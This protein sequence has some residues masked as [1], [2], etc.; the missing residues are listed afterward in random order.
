MEH[1]SSCPRPSDR[2]PASIA[3][4]ALQCTGRFPFAPISTCLSKGRSP[5]IFAVTHTTVYR[6]SRADLLRILRLTARQLGS[7][8]KAGLGAAAE[9][10][11]LFD[12]FQ[13]KTLA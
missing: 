1:C 12:L 5:I 4:F 8:E 2:N 11:S 3:Q 6:Y 9:N 7:W 10:Y 13:I